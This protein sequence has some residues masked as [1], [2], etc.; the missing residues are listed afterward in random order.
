MTARLPSERYRAALVAHGHVADPA[1]ERAVERLDRVWQELKS[2]ESPGVLERLKARLAGSPP[3]RD[4]VRGLYMWGGVGRGK[5]F[6]MDIFFHALPF[7]KKLRLHFHR[8]MRQVHTDLKTLPDVEDPLRAVA[9]RLAKRTRIICFDEFFVSDIADAMILGRLFEHLFGFGV[10]LVT[11]SNIPPHELYKDGLQRVYFLPAI[12]QIEQNCEILNVDAGTDYRLQA[13]ESVQIYHWPLDKAADEA[14]SGYFIKLNPDNETTDRSVTV[15]DRAIAVR[16]R[17]D[18]VI[19]FDF[20]TLCEGPRS[21][22]DYIELAREFHTVFLS[23][24]PAM[25]WTRDNDARR[26]ITLIDE[27]YDRNVKLILSA[28]V[29]VEAIYTGDTLRFEFRRVLSRLK[30]MQSTHYLS[31]RHCT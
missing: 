14:M 16:K 10:S 26:F 2:H 24:V 28:E 5:T 21:A 12:A 4:P 15:N 29:P 25:D 23:E 19:W 6:L 22:A 27:F 31:R 7:E 9:A 3:E 1:Q 8:F 20:R 30:E 13:L 11:T 18:G 17:G